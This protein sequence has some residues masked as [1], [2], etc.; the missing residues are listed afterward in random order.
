MTSAA[1]ESAHLKERIASELNAA[2][3][4]TLRLLEPLSDDELRAQHSPLMSPLV[5]DLAH[6]GHFEEL[7]LVRAWRNAS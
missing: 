6:I 1:L 5:W 4:R 3:E 7:W 2:R